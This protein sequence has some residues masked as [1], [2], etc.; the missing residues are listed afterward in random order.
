MTGIILAAGSGGRMSDLGSR[1]PKCLL[2]VG[3]RTLLDRQIAALQSAGV[4][5]IA[6]VAGHCAEQVAARVGP[7]VALVQNSRFAATNSLYSLWLARHWIED[8]GVVLN[9]DVL[10]HDQSLVDLLGARC[11]D[12][13][14]VEARPS[15]FDDEEMKVRIRHGCVTDISKTLPIDET[16]AESLG[17]AKFGRDGARL[18]LDEAGRLLASGEARAWLPAAFQRFCSRRPLRAVDTRGYPWI[19]IDFPDDYRRA[20]TEVLPAI[21]AIGG[22]GTRTRRSPEPTVQRRTGCHV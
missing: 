22:I 4:D 14:L 16:D 8:G 7:R 1:L 18:L 2:R 3:A 15:Q 5:R 9:G 13:L 6:I 19:E 21:E 20:C 11:E 12:A 10:F 17:I